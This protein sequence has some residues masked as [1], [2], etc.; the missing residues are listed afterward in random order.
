M[1]AAP[2]CIEL[3]RQVQIGTALRKLFGQSFNYYDG[4]RLRRPAVR[5]ARGIRRAGA[6]RIAGADRGDPAGSL[7]RPGASRCTR[8]FQS[9]LR[10]EGATNWPAEYPE[11]FRDNIP[12]LAGYT[13]ADGSDHRTRG[14][15][16]QS[17]RVEFDFQRTELA[18]PRTSRANARPARQRHHAGV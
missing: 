8:A 6:Q 15:F 5:P 14:Y 4:E 2:A 10:P 9:Y 13:F 18:A 3:Y 11:E 16:A 1:T 7:S 12:A 17:S